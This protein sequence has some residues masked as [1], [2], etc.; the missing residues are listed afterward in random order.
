VDLCEDH[1]IKGKNR[2]P[3]TTKEPAND[4]QGVGTKVKSPSGK[5]RASTSNRGDNSKKFEKRFDSVMCA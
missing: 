5:R 4:Y 3:V 2:S 1:Q